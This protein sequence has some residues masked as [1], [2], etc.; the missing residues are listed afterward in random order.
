MQIATVCQHTLGSVKK[1]EAKCRGRKNIE[2][3]STEVES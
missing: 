3:E 2:V 1:H